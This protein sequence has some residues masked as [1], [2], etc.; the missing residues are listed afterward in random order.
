MSDRPRDP[1]RDSA[2]SLAAA[3]RSGEVTSRALVDATIAHA[4][5]VN[6]L[7]NAIVADRFADARAD[8]DAADRRIV[9]ARAAGCEEELPPL[10]GVPCTIKESFEVTGMPNTS[11]LVARQGVRAERDAVTVRRLREAGAV[12]LGVTNTSELCMWMESSN[13]VYGR[14]N[15]PYDLRRIVGGSSGGE[16]A[17]V[18]AAY[19]PFG[20]GAD[21]GGSIRMPA[22]FNG[23][24]GHK[25]SGRLIPNAG[26]YPLGGP[27]TQPFLCTGPLCRRAEDLMPLV[28]LLAGPDPEDGACVPMELGDPA[29]V[30]LGGMRVVHIPD[31]GRIGVASTLR[32]SQEDAVAW[33]RAAGADVQV[34]RPPELR[35]SVEIWG[36]MLEAA[37]G[38]T[39]RSMLA[40][41][42]DGF[43]AP[44]EFM[45]W[46]SR[47]S[48]HTLPA[49]M[50]AV[51]E[52]LPTAAEAQAR[53]FLQSG[54]SLRNRLED[55]VGDNGIFLYPS[56]ARPAPRHYAPLL[57]PWR[58][59]YTAILNV[60]EVPVTQV[61][62]GLD[63]GGRPLGVQVGGRRGDDHRTI[64][65]AEAL[66]RAFGGWV[67]PWESAVAQRRGVG[68]FAPS[69]ALAS[70][71]GV[72]VVGA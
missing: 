45:R 61:P 12:V 41:G 68:A 16:G 47:R 19:A 59:A 17:A 10:L 36:A 32:K 24:F 66:E 9:A 33:L 71:R 28:R 55:L 57:L 69:L 35:R 40:D 29:T 54:E 1:F 6:P 2:R 26:Q 50:L 44:V 21:V 37:G 70:G 60:M 62:L 53:A 38:P 39:F 34:H 8:A 20:L 4:Q 13:R 23:V 30:D 22:F 27:E 25:P 43:S 5:V 46:A 52:T 42:R 14:T 64:A 65:V 31:D 72:G 48:P 63:A 56:H 15:N 3:L 51:L 18:G 7:L 67:P 58:W 49:L 11:G